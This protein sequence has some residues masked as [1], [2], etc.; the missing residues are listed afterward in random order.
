VERELLDFVHH[1]SAQRRYA[2]N[3]LA[4]YYADLTLLTEYLHTQSEHAMQSWADVTPEMLL[5][6]LE[7]LR[8]AGRS[9]STISRKTVSIR[10]FFRYL[11]GVEAILHNPAD[12]LAAP[13]IERQ[14]A[15]SL[16]EAETDRLRQA[17]ADLDTPKGLRDR[18]LLELLCTTGLRVSELA[19]LQLDDVDLEEGTTVGAARNSRER[20]I[21]LEP[22]TCACIAYYLEQGRAHLLKNP[23][24]TTFFLNHRGHP[25]TRQGVWL[26]IKTYASQVGLADV[27]TPS[28]L[29]RTFAIR[30]LETG[31]EPSTVQ[32]LLG[33]AS[34]TT[35]RAYTRRSSS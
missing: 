17:P 25:L 27:I 2:R 29:R 34:V 26:I 5:A 20:V 9:P 22:E 32:H 4:A 10:A 13:P 24:E 21:N 7:A 30:L 18:A 35:T 23:E 28:T 8:R 11:V 14:P 19:A 6:Y 31:V 1:L 15:A 33:H 16:S 3:T 12:E